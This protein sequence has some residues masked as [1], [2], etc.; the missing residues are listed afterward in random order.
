M[1]VFIEGADFGSLKDFYTVRFP[2][3]IKLA[4]INAINDT[5]SYGLKLATEEMLKE[6]R[7]PAG[8]LDQP[9]R[10]Y[11]SQFAQDGFIEAH[12]TAR[13]RAT[14]LS[15]FALP[16]QTPFSTRG[17]S[18]LKGSGPGVNVEVNPGQVRNIG[19]AF[20]MAFKNGNYGIAVRTKGATS[21]QARLKSKKFFSTAQL[22][23][24]LYILYGPSVDQVFQS[25]AKDIAERVRIHLM[26]SFI[27][28]LNAQD[29]K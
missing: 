8:Y 4:Q 5:A 15:R 13:G 14:A 22:T 16:G 18:S 26:E 11:I 25:V 7:F 9:K 2:Q 19:S 23:N 28:Q 20:I 17:A 29:G 12:I 24:D 1:T 21:V 3:A 27:T 6:V 10:F